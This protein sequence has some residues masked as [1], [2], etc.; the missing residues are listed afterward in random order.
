MANRI[1]NI[2]V[3]SHRLKIDFMKHAKFWSITGLVAVVVSVIYVGIHGLNYSIDFLG[4]TEINFSTTNAEIHSERIKEIVGQAGV[5]SFEVNEF[6]NPGSKASSFVVRLQR[7]PGQAEDQVSQ[8]AD[9]MVGTLKQAIGPEQFTLDS[10]TN[11]SGKV[12]KE[13]ERRGYLAV[14]ISFMAI[15]AYIWYRFDMRFAPGAVACLLH[16][17]SI[18][19]AIMT[20]LERPFNVGSIAAYLTVIGYSINDTVIVYDRI[21][22]T[23]TVNPRL[24]ARD[25]INL[26]INQTLNRT[27]LTS[28]SAMMALIVLAV[29]G[30][31]TIQDFALTMLIGI[32]VGTFSSIF[33]AA[34]MSLLTDNWLAS[35]GIQFTDANKKK[36]AKD[37]DF[38]PP[39]VLKR[40]PTPPASK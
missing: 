15:M 26:S 31:G 28:T 38:C 10:I 24:S 9:S 22:E 34:P 17:V 36:A 20:F 11:I 5:S 23:M 19:L 30:G 21:R 7:E 29:Y 37:P 25:A 13:E 14:I 3:F 35:R 27:I 40:K 1:G 39:V 12:G 33:V 18:A 16:D 4:G 6:S 8:A 2:T 32:I